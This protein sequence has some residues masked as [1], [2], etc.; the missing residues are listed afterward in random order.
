MQKLIERAPHAQCTPFN[1]SGGTTAGTGKDVG[2]GNSGTSPGSSTPGGGGSSVHFSNL[3]EALKTIW[4]AAFQLMTEQLT[5][6]MIHQV[7]A[8]GMMF[9]AKEQMEAQRDFQERY[10]QA[11]KDY[12]PSE[13]MCEIGTMVRNL[14]NTDDRARLTALTVSNRML[15]RELA[16]GDSMTVE[17]PLSDTR[18]R[19]KNFRDK[20]CTKQ[21]NGGGLK[22][23]CETEADKKRLNRDVDFIQSVEVPLTLPVDFLDTETTPEEEDL[24]ALVNYLFMHRTPIQIPPNYTTNPDFPKLYQDLRSVIAMRGVARNSIA[25]IIAEKTAGPKNE[26][27]NVNNAA[28]Y[29]K[30]LLKEFGLSDEEIKAMVGDRPSY[31]AQMEILTKKVYQH[32]N[33]VVNLY[34]K[35]TNVKRIRAAMR[36]IKLMQDRDIHEAL[37]RREMLLSMI[38]EARLRVYQDTLYNRVNATI[39][40]TP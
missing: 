10:A 18:S 13:Q 5:A 31:F 27:D 12:H 15:A 8:V 28:P 4:V 6:A 2:A 17:G 9:D 37:L 35:P 3:A 21:D 23:L 40:F 36:A 16:T 1:V 14:A 29:I 30:S 34:D 26:D 33:F 25:H 24:F 11:H 39:Q 7:Q 38:L 20:H 32:P 22:N 19:L